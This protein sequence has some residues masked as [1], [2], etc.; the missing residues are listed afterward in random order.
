MKIQLITPI[1]IATSLMTSTGH[2]TAPLDDVIQKSQKDM[3]EK[4]QKK[5]DAQLDKLLTMEDQKLKEPNPT[6]ALPTIQPAPKTKESNP[7]EGE[8]DSLQLFLEKAWDWI[9]GR[10]K[11]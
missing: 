10:D 11:E 7:T 4:L 5:L 2:C 6:A 3:N 9:I 8:L 1:L